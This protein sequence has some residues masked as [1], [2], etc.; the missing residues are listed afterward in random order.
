MRAG[1]KYEYDRRDSTVS[2]PLSLIPASP[3]YVTDHQS[4][5]SHLDGKE[6]ETRGLSDKTFTRRAQ[7]NDEGSNPKIWKYCES[8]DVPDQVP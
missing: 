5:R 8:N 2:S 3:D 7:T 4:G 1:R 6:E